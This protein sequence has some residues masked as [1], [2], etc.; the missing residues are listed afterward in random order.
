MRFTPVI[1]PMLVIR[2]RPLRPP[3]NLDAILV[4]IGNALSALSPSATPLLAVGDATAERAP[5]P[6]ASATSSARPGTPTPSWPSPSPTSPRVPHCCSRTGA[7]QGANLA[8]GLRAAGFRVH[9]R[10]A[11]AALPARRFP[12]AATRSLQQ[13]RLRAALFLSAETA[14]TFARLLPSV[15]YPALAEVDA[16]VIGQP[17]ADALAPLPWRRVRVSL[18]PNPGAG[19]GL[20]MSDDIPIDPVTIPPDRARIEPTPSARRRDILPILYLLG[21]AVLAF[22]LVYLYRHPMK[23]RGALQEAQQVN[24]L[25]QD[26]DAARQENAALA[27]RLKQV[28]DRPVTAPIDLAPVDARLRALEARPLP[29][30]R[31]PRPDPGPDRRG[32]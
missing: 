32:R 29:Q 20:A 1:A 11:Y 30:P 19:I 2:P 17:A 18:A 7:G 23:T 22:T 25:H 4:T 24:S 12:E 10:V 6:P 14:R 28:E 26:L 31:R 15:L 16:L 3:A 21:F 5:A 8:A 9:R 27:A 13:G